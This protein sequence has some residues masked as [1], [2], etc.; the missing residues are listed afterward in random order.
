MVKNWVIPD[1]HGCIFTLKTLIEKQIKPNKN[2]LLIF[3]GDYIDRGPDS[4]GVIDYIMELERNEFNVTALLGNHEDYCI[5][6]YEDDIKRMG[7]LGF[8]KKTK[9]QREWENYGGVETLASF[10]AES[11]RDIPKKYIDWL[12]ALDYYTEVD[13]FIIVHAGLNFEEDDPFADK[14]AMIW[15]RDFKVDSKKISNKKIIHG[16]VPVNLEFIE[17]SINNSEYKFIDLDNGIYIN[18]RAGYGN[19]VALELTEMKLVIQ[20]LMDDVTYRK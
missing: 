16:H 15:I 19:L 5:K 18:D 13:N 2:D 20:S 1:I 9:I 14:R 12:K 6:A 4:K 11:P 8:R 3:L 10:D 17:L 7:F